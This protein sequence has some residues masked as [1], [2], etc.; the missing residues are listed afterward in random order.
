MRQNDRAKGF[1]CRERERYDCVFN[2]SMAEEVEEV[3][4]ERQK[5]QRAKEVLL[6]YGLEDR[7]SHSWP[8]LSCSVLVERLR[9]VRRKSH[10]MTH[11]AYTFLTKHQLTTDMDR[12]LKCNLTL[13]FI[14]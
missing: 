13:A 3:Y 2:K 8:D 6:L 12:A 1:R 10:K 11:A 7:G 5:G 4:R 9:R 14:T